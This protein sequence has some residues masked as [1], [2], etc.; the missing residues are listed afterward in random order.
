VIIPDPSVCDNGTGATPAACMSKPIFSRTE[1]VPSSCAP[2][3]T[4]DAK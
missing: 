2:P 4:V 1:N 3:D